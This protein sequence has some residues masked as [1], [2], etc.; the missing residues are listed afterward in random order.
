LVRALA[1]YIETKKFEAAI[2]D[3]AKAME[4][5]DYDPDPYYYRGTC[6]L[7]LKKKELACVDLAK[8]T[9]VNNKRLLSSPWTARE[10]AQQVIEANCK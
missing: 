1:A 5:R 4:L 8:A 3:F 9:E 10:K 6:Y 2:D 7:A